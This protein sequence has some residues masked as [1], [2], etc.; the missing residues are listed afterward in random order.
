MPDLSKPKVLVVDDEAQLRELLADALSDMPIQVYAASSGHEAQE[1]ARQLRPDILVTDLKLGDCTGLD[2]I[3]RLRGTLGDIPAV[4]ITGVRDPQW[5]CEASRRKPVELM[6][7]PLDLGR[8]KNTIQRELSVL[9]KT[10]NEMGRTSRLR[11]L[12]KQVNKERKQAQRQLQNTCADLTEAYHDLTNQ[13]E[14]QQIAVQ[15]QQELLQ[16]R[17]DDDVFRSL[18]KTFVNQSGPLNGVALVCDANAELQVAGRFGVPSPDNIEFCQT[19][20]APH[21]DAVIGNPQITVTDAGDQAE[22]FDESI[23]RYLPGVTTLSIP[24]LPTEGELIGLV[25]LY[26]KGEQPFLN[27]DLIL[28]ELLGPPTALAVRRNE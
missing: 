3:D 13:L 6:T 27:E 4:V 10:R 26:R 28:A 11:R 24:L 2:V 5:F 20:A 7:K 18:F 16:S 21:I 17:C 25:L 12:A 9:F 23:R 22:V 15:Y 14:A 1:I 19:L 8:L